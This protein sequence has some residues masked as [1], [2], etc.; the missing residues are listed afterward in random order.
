[1]FAL[2]HRAS[3]LL[4]QTQYCDLPPSEGESGS[5]GGIE[6]RN[7]FQQLARTVSSLVVSLVY[8]PKHNITIM[9]QMANWFDQWNSWSLAM[10]TDYFNAGAHYLIPSPRNRT[11]EDMSEEGFSQD[12]DDFISGLARHLDERKTSNQLTPRFVF[13][14]YSPVHMNDTLDGEF[15]RGPTLVGCRPFGLEASRNNFRHRI[16]REKF[17]RANITVLSINEPSSILFDEHRGNLDCR[18]WNQPGWWISGLN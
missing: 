17:L 7:R 10:K 13:R 4:L 6:E 16:S 14:E 9:L 3:F 5:G 8:F 12:V 15:I 1:L 11:D 18:H 2:E